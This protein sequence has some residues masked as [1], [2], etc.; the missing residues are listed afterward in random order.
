MTVGLK[1]YPDMKYSSIKWLGKIPEY[2]RA[3]LSFY[4]SSP[5]ADNR[6]NSKERNGEETE[7]SAAHT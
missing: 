2:W 3:C 6:D 7:S 1:P 4:W 5:R